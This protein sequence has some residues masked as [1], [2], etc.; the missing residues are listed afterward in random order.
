MKIEKNRIFYFFVCTILSLMIICFMKLANNNI[1]FLFC[2]E[3]FIL[4]EFFLNIL[5]NV[6]DR[7]NPFSFFLLTIFLGFLD[8]VL[9]VCDIRIISHK[10]SINIYEKSLLL[11]IVWI[12]SFGVAYV[13]KYKKNKAKKIHIF[14][15]MDNVINSVNL[16]SLIIVSLIIQIFIAYKIIYT[17][18]QIGNITQAMNDFS[19]FRYN[20][21][22]YLATMFPLLSI[23][24][25]AL[26]EKGYKKNA[27]CSM[28][29]NFILITLTGRRGVA[30]NT[31]IIT[32]IV[33][34]NYRVKKINNKK[35]FMVMVPLIAFIIFIG[36]MR[37]QQI[38]VNSTNFFARTVS[39]ITNTIQYG[40]NIPD[41]LYKIDSKLI[42]FQ[43]DK[44]I[45][46]GIL[47]MIPR[48]F[49]DNKPEV[50]HSLITSKLV[51][52]SDIDYGKPVG[53]FGFAYLCFGYFGVVLSGFLCGYFTCLLYKWMLQKKN[54][55][56]IIIY[57][58]LI[59]S[60]IYITLPES[61][62]KII[63][64]F[65]IFCVIS[66]FSSMKNGKIILINKKRNE[67]K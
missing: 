67:E 41:L 53:A 55:L 60:F 27:I 40:Q 65:V 29:L 15:I 57:S 4:F 13:I 33:Y 44:Y 16:K 47:G 66:V 36:N 62:T 2:F 20:N 1:S 21:Q 56:P 23:V 43:K 63:T 39:Y 48:A 25:I 46:N 9:V 51:Y 58:V 37:N 64:L 42:D 17:I 35:I 30:I 14:K 3:A 31:V 19:V 8:I 28:I 6:N 5:I 59:Q 50:D 26:Y 34:Y 11:F 32:F 10:Y 38:T 12:L 54:L 22:G 24:S 61:Q 7:F 49:W 45:F 52:Y 18:I